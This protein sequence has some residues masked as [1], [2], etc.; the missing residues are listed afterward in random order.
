[1]SSFLGAPTESVEFVDEIDD[2]S[3][4][5]S[6]T[7][8]SGESILLPAFANQ[9]NVKMKEKPTLYVQ[10]TKKGVEV[11]CQSGEDQVLHIAPDPI[12]FRIV[13]NFT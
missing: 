7:I 10:Q 12:C 13:N 8:P 4:I 2:Q 11:V 5:V 6:I 3:N 1:M 9:G